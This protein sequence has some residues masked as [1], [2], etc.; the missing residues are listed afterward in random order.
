[1]PDDLADDCPPDAENSTDGAPAPR[2]APSQ[3]SDKADIGCLIILGVTFIGIFLLPAAFLLGGAPLI[4]PLITCLLLALSAPFIN[5]LERRSPKAKWWGRILTFLL[6]AGL[7]VAA[8]LWLKRSGDKM[9]DD[10][11]VSCT[12]PHLLRAA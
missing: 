3:L 8:W 5:P 1:M 10:D 7:V 11:E 4:I 2:P 6:L 12:G 9:V